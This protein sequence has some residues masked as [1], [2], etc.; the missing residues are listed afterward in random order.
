MMVDF[1]TFSNCLDDFAT[2]PFDCRL[3]EDMFDLI[4]FDMFLSYLNV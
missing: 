4:L 3:D 2:S 1:F